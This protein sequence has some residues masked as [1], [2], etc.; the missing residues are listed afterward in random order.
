MRGPRVDP[1]FLAKGNEE[2]EDTFDGRVAICLAQMKEEWLLN[3]RSDG[4]KA[5]RSLHFTS[6]P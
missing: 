5:V 2:R 1:R 4:L 3:T 6:V